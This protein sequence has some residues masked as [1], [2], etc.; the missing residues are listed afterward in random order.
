[1]N[2]TKKLNPYLQ[3][4]RQKI[5][6]D[7]YY[8]LQTREEI[9]IAVEL[10]LK[11][12]VNQATV[13][14]WLR[15]PGISIHQARML[16]ELINMGLQLLSLEDLAATLRVPLARLKPLEPILEFCYYDAESVLTPQ[17]INPNLASPKEWEQI[18][19]LDADTIERI[20]AHRQ[21]EGDY[22]NLADFQRRLRLNSQLISQLI[23]YITF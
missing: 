12:D 2:F 10:G 6:K 16:V 9:A 13:D 3:G 1:M 15:L 18:P 7:P 17:R 20:I 19:L 14:D 23:H 22:Q 4:I 5:L 8:R 11:I 21:Q